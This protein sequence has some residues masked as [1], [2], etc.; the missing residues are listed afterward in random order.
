MTRIHDFGIAEAQRGGATQSPDPWEIRRRAL[1]TTVFHEVDDEQRRTRKAQA[2]AAVADAV[3]GAAAECGRNSRWPQYERKPSRDGG[4]KKSEYKQSCLGNFID[5]TDLNPRSNRRRLIAGDHTQEEKGGVK[6]KPYATIGDSTLSISS[7]D[8]NGGRRDDEVAARSR[9]PRRVIDPTRHITTNSET[10]RDT[11]GSP[12]STTDSAKLCDSP[13]VS[14]KA[15]SNANANANAIPPLHSHPSSSAPGFSPLAPSAL[16]RSHQ[17]AGILKFDQIHQVDPVDERPIE[18]SVGQTDGLTSSNERFLKLLSMELKKPDAFSPATPK[19]DGAAAGT[20][21]RER[22]R[23][24]G[25]EGNGRDVGGG[26][27]EEQEFYTTS[28]QCGRCGRTFAD[29]DRVQK[30]LRGCRPK[31]RQPEKSTEENGIDPAGSQ[32][33]SSRSKTGPAGGSGAGSG[34]CPGAV[35]NRQGPKA[36]PSGSK[37]TPCRHCGRTFLAEALQR[38]EPICLKVFHGKR[39]LSDRTC[40]EDVGRRGLATGAKEK[41]KCQTKAGATRPSVRGDGDC[42]GEAVD[43][44]VTP[45][46]S[47]WSIEDAV[48]RGVWS[49]QLPQ[50]MRDEKMRRLMEMRPLPLEDAASRPRAIALTGRVKKHPESRRETPLR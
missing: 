10:P 33:N 46:D 13:A 50:W 25:H 41:L 21:G 39:S 27:K 20:A 3:A 35:A 32:P 47:R 43:E 29:Y 23:A 9:R 45:L 11:L 18:S 37:L 22:E 17:S 34:I 44:E 2:L 7:L 31:L 15:L 26:E 36:S 19:A 1:P 4:A 42:E 28:N 38:H 30:H 40:Q 14:S 6:W 12:E 16:R 48:E 8:E 5:L 24:A 49:R